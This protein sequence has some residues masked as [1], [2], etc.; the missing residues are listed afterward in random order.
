MQHSGTKLVVALTSL[1]LILGAIAWWYRYE[2]AHR[3]TQFWGAANARLIA[4]SE[5]LEALT[6]DPATTDV[7]AARDPRSLG[8]SI[9]LS[10]ARGQAHLRH[11]LM[12][13]HNYGWG[14]SPA[15]AEIHW[16][17]CLRFHESNL[18]AF[19]VLSDDLTKIGKYEPTTDAQ[20]A[21]TLTAVSCQPMTSSLVQYF[22]ALGLLAPAS[23]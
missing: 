14:K 21:D 13:D 4:E 16:K 15:T 12:S 9:D 7:V 18:Q 10:N 19:V 8:M 5:N 3:A 17:W 23:E 2:A 11:A 22:R 20:T 6:F 1:A